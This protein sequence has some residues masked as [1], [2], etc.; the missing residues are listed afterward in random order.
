MNVSKEILNELALSED[1]YSLIVKR[2]GRHPNRLELGMFGSL[3][4]EHCGYKHSKP[5]L[6]LFK[7]GSNNLLIE[8]GKENA[9]VVEIGNGL[10]I[11]MKIESHNHPSAIEPFEGAAT[12]VGGIVRDIFAMGARP[13]AL[14]NSLRFG[15]LSDSRNR[16]L[17]EE[18]VSGI[19]SYGNC[20][21]IP[22]VGGEVFFEK[23]YSGNP[24]VNAMC[25]GIV[26]TDNLIR[27]TTGNE[28]NVL[29]LVGA[30]TGKD[31][32]HGA[33]GLA[34][35]SFDDEQDLRPTVQV[36]NPFLEKVLIEACMEVS[37]KEFLV[38]IQDLGAAGLTSAI[39]ESAAKAGSGFEIDI[40][41]I[42]KREEGM[43]AY[44]VMLSESQER[45]LI[46]V[47]PGTENLVK[48]IF[49]K[50]DLQSS[51]I[52]KVTGDGLARIFD[53]GII[54]CEAPI[55]I[56][57]DSPT[58]KLKG[59]KPVVLD[60]L[61]AFDFS[62]IL[63]PD[64]PQ[65]ILLK[66]LSSPNIISRESIYRQYDHQ[67]QTNTVVSPGSDSALLRIKGSSK[68]IALATDCNSRYVYL[69]PY[70][71]GIIAVAEACRNLS[72][73][74]AKPLALTDCLNFGNPE[75]PEI[76]YQL[77]QCIKGISYASNAFSAPVISGNVS[78]YNESYGENIY[79]TPVLGAL[80][81]L[82]DSKKYVTS[83]F[84]EEG[85]QVILLGFDEL[86]PGGFA[87]SEYMANI[88]GLIA[89]KPKIDLDLE[90][91]IQS[92]C[93]KLIDK[94]I[95]NSAH[96]CSEGG[97]AIALAESSILSKIGF[98]GDF[99]FSGRWDEILFGELQSRIVVSVKPNKLKE[100]T[101]VCSA[102][103]IKWIALGHTGGNSFEINNLINI[104]IKQLRSVWDQAL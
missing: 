88:H 98:I 86:L 31:G 22:N 48:E 76:Y 70:V 16:Y 19:S 97:L 55:N 87:G 62:D 45:M 15:P 10:G 41:N 73:T 63:I 18:V 50:W 93:R 99:E 52:G 60:S 102:D 21:G 34:S 59:E 66:L 95:I 69:D 82:E 54:Q 94:E 49:D 92:I 100:F 71:G 8:P 29:I 28:G 89:G 81:I 75:N 5:L 30:D 2:L 91:K 6:D 24:L 42:P 43:D 58:Y 4:S 40:S 83:Q 11:V 61:Q 7:T 27:A 33:S 74:G 77:E 53:K 67:V 64:S 46:I 20:I 17:F 72:V 51:V 84:I 56:L 13:I 37:N 25:V 79:P 23:C 85:D 1:E 96:D 47:K 104:P 44:D 65:E 12:G 68:S 90:V 14:L 103:E 32:I 3:W 101:S 78:L 39:V 35:Q 57:A 9:G 38:G 26:N 80:G 36:G